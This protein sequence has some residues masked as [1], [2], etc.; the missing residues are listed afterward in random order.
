MFRD[1]FLDYDYLLSV[2]DRAENGPVLEEREWDQVYIY[3]TISELAEKYDVRWEKNC[4]CVPADDALADRAFEAG[5]ELAT[6]CGLFCLDTRRRMI[7]SREELDQLLASC[8]ARVVI[9]SGDDQV[10]IARRRPDDLTR[11]ATVGGAYGTQVPEELFIPL[12][13]SYAQERSLDFIDNASLVTTRGRPIRANS[14]W[15]AIG[16]W[17]EMEMSFKVVELAG[18]PG[19]PIGCAEDS[20]SAIGE[21]ATTTYG[22]F[23]PTDWHHASFVSELKTS[24]AE[25]IKSVHYAHTRTF[26]HNFYNPIY[27]G[28]IGSGAGLAI[29]TV[30]GMVLMKACYGGVTDNPGPSHAHLSCDTYPDMITAQAVAFQGL[31]RNTNVLVS[32]FVRPVGGPGTREILYE[33]AAL[34][35]ASVP[36]GIALMEGV[37]SAMGRFTGHVS[38]LEARFMAEVAQAATRL[39]RK[40]ADRMVRWLVQ[41]FE[42]RQKEMPV[43]K[44]FNEVYDLKTIHPLPEWQ[45]TYEQVCQ[46]LQHELGLK[47]S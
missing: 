29:A 25:L 37:Q 46:E 9:G 33:T 42:A 34:T 44:P 20:P 14:P 16:C 36:S 38:G 32:S 18:R 23:R 5:M 35:I 40:E 19:M 1:A 28:Y 7:W 27:G 47:V 21:L 13:L 2:L 4:G 3:R 11:V 12:M 22:G 15:E 8:P 6:R 30:A 26:A 43:G 24:Y 41:K 10:V 39:D 45:R 31:S 17:Q